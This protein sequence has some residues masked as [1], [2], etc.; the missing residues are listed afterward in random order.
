MKSM[1]QYTVTIRSI[2]T[3]ADQFFSNKMIYDLKEFAAVELHSEA[4]EMVIKID[5]IYVRI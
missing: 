4:S 3:D 1:L 5:G 2:L